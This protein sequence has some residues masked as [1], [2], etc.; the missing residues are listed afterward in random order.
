MSWSWI[1][2]ITGQWPSYAYKEW[3]PYASIVAKFLARRDKLF[4][5]INDG[6][7]HNGQQVLSATVFCCS[8]YQFIA[9]GGV[10]SATLQ[11]KDVD[12]AEG[13]VFPPES[14]LRWFDCLQST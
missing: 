9:T 6:L 14:M 2:R 12:R 8:D 1:L 5:K 7:L 10:K 4:N 3:S 11:A 13:S